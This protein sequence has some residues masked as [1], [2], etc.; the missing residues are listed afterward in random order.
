MDKL[1][2]I[3]TRSIVIVPPTVQESRTE[4]ERLIQVSI[5]LESL[6]AREEQ[7]IKLI[8]DCLYDVGYVSFINKKVR[9]R[10]INSIAKSVAKMSKPV[11]RIFAWR[12]FQKNC[13][14]IITNWLSAKVKMERK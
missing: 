14:Q 2:P 8:I 10:S 7:T 9:W 11:F 13:P 4:A 3:P 1:A 6:F 12:W 5:L